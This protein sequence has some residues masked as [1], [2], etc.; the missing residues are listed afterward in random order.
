MARRGNA[1]TRLM[2]EIAAAWSE[3]F[4]PEG[5]AW[6]INSGKARAMENPRRLIDMAPAG[7]PDLVC[8]LRGQMIGLEVKTASGAPES[9]QL[10]MARTW[11]TAG[12]V[13]L[14]VTSPE[15]AIAQT[16]AATRESV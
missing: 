6:R 14:F 2:A 12:G 8:L 4:H 1:E 7:W 13:Y 15:D 16:E 5:V 9:S 3:R 10:E 11:R